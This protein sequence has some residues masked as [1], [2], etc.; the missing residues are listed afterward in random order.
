MCTKNSQ[1]ACVARTGTQCISR[2]ARQE[3]DGVGSRGG[4][5]VG[6]LPT[7]LGSCPASHFF[8][9]S[10]VPA[11]PLLCRLVQ[12]QLQHQY[13]FSAILQILYGNTQATNPVQ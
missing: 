10:K 9:T 4:R 2:Q 5:A 3:V 8:V 7:S 11:D 1:E 12:L 6:V 13:L